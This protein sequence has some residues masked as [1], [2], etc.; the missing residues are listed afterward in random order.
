MTIVPARTSSRLAALAL[1]GAALVAGGCGSSSSN[2]NSSHSGAQASAA[3]AFQRAAYV[4]SAASGYRVAIH[5]REGSPVL[6]GAITGQGTG[7]FNLPR[8]AGSMNLT[9]A[10]PPNLG[11]V[12]PLSLR[13]VLSGDIVYVKLP[14][15]L[16]SKLPGAKPWIEIN[17]AQVGKAAGLQGLSSLTGGPGSTNPGQF[18]QYLRAAS[19]GGVHRVGPATVDG[20]Q[21]THYRATVDLSR[22]AAAAPAAQRANLRQAIASLQKL[23]GLRQ[24]PVDVWVDPQHLVRRLALAYKATISGQSLSTQMR[25]DFLS[26]A[27]QPVPATPPAGQV[28]NAGALLSAAGGSGL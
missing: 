20:F 13:E 18:L 21:T 11:A 23:T 7:S 4:S 26:Y 10:L 6:G 9:L 2:S 17:L 5:L 3:G 16:A 28:T 27:S 8:R 1:A 25:L 14:A 24:M 19:S 15:V 12:G 22:V